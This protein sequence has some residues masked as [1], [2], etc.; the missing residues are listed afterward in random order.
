MSFFAMSFSALVVSGCVG[1][2]PL[3]EEAGAGF[4]GMLGF[5]RND[6]D[7]P[8]PRVELVF[9]ENESTVGGDSSEVATVDRQL[10][11][12]PMAVG[13]DPL[14]GADLGAQEVDTVALLQSLGVVQVQGDEGLA[15]AEVPGEEKNESQHHQKPSL[16]AEETKPTSGFPDHVGKDTSGSGLLSVPR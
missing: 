14:H 9:V 7:R 4:D 11:L 2:G 15:G 12:D 16:G 6:V 1:R 10:D 8:S 13:I 5:T 3:A